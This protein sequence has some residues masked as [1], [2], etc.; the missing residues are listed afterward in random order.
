M[1]LVPAAMVFYVSEYVLLWSGLFVLRTRLQLKAYALSLMIATL[2]GG[3]GFV[4]LPAADVFPTPTDEQL[5]AWSGLFQ[6][7]R[8][9]A[10]RSNFFPSLHV[11]FSTIA[12]M[13][14]CD[15]AGAGVRLLLVTWGVVIAASTLLTQEH[16]LVDVVGGLLLG[17]GVVRW[18]YR[19]MTSV[20][21]VHEQG[22]EMPPPN[23]DRPPAPKA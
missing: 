4:A 1:P 14:Y 18:S 3:I 19:P 8:W 7:A 17:W 21:L 5:G 22:G 10:L 9:V 12:V 6:L 23:Q 16:Y 11:A 15:F 20:A 13:I 2:V